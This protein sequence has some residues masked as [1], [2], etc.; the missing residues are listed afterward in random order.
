[1]VHHHGIGK[2]RTQWTHQEHGSA[3]PL[4]TGLK[5]AF[6]PNG[7]MNPGTIFPLAD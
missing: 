2:Y 4:L 1:M 6:D 5:R 7:I 3:Y